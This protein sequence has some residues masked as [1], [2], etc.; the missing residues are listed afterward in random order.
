M[1]GWISS[2]SPHSKYIVYMQIH[3][4]ETVS[5]RSFGKGR[6]SWTSFRNL[7]LHLIKAKSSTIKMERGFVVRKKDSMLIQRGGLLDRAMGGMKSALTP[8]T[9]AGRFLSNASLL[10]S[11]P[12]LIW[13]YS[14]SSLERRRMDASSSSSASLSSIS[15]FAGTST[16]S[17]SGLL[18]L[19]FVYIS[20][21][22]D[23]WTNSER[24]SDLN[25]KPLKSHE[26]WD[27]HKE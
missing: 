12:L 22:I 21:Q 20:L 27:E 2:R 3:T 16:S 15:M 4:L 26:F 19:F 24:I 1:S 8:D 10:D 5:A 9:V 17:F 7:Y 23:L 13:R 25:P 11:A 14:C 6:Q 18:P